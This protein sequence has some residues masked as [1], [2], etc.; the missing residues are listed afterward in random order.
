MKISEAIPAVSALLDADI[1]GYLWSAPGVGKSEVMAAVAASRGAAFYDIRLN[2]FDPVDL[3]GLPAI[4]SGKTAWM[5]PQIW[6]DDPSRETV[7]FFDEMDRATPAVMSAAMQIVLD[8]RIGEHVLP[9]SVR[10][11][12]AGNGKTDR[13]GTNRMPDALANRFCHIEIEPDAEAWR[14]W[15]RAAGIP[16]AM[17]DF[18]GFRPALLHRDTMPDA[19]RAALVTAG[20]GSPSPRAWVRASKLL[21]LPDAVRHGLI[22]GLVGE[23][24]AGEF[25]GFYRAFRELPPI[26]SI[27]AD[28]MGA[29]VPAASEASA[30]YAVSAAL[31]RR[32]TVQNF[33]AALAYAGRLPREF[34]IVTAT[35]AVRRDPKLQETAAFTAWAVRNQDVTL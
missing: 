9:P 7:L 16:A 17:V 25:E 14:A 4:E 31:A 32:A 28:P 13:T 12:A 15:A 33:G 24:P 2:L 5:R 23:A 1:P 20:K 35:D 10:I 6:P 11:V 27:F 8:R 30:V 26:D 19:Q 21:S 29:K 22:K 18:I 34:E 3:R